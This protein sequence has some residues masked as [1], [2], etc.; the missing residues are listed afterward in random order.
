MLV[1]RSAKLT[2]NRKGLKKKRAPE[3]LD[4]KTSYPA[5]PHYSMFTGR[6]IIQSSGNL[7]N[8]RLQ[9]KRKQIMGEHTDRQD[10]NHTV[11]HIPM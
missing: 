9:Q 5:A 8:T 11:I 4:L 10:N 2:L 1:Y 7:Y 6:V 3:E